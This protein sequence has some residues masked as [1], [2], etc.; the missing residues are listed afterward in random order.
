LAAV[1]APAY[2]RARQGAAYDDANDSRN[3][4]GGFD[5]SRSPNMPMHRV[6]V[7]GMVMLNNMLPEYREASNYR[8]AHSRCSS[9]VAVALM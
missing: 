4:N 1:P 3:S 5:E 9:G 6:G 7:R 8:I 2:P